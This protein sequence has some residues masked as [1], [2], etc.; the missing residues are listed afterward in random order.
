V[1]FAKHENPPVNRFC[2]LTLYDQDH[3]FEPNEIKRYL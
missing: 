3:F 1:T 2:S